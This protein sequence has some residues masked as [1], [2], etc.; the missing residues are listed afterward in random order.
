M[1]GYKIP[2]NKDFTLT[3]AILLKN[4][5]PAPFSIE[6]TLMAEYKE[7]MWAGISYRNKDAVVGMFGMSISEKFKF[8]YSY[9]F[10]VSEMDKVSS[11]GHELVLGIMLGR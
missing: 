7:W 9:D 11:G 6:G 3:P 8:G 4:M 5:R 10:S 2:I 1:G